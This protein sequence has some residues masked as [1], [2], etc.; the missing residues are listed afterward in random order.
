MDSDK[1]IIIRGFNKLFFEMLDDIILVFPDNVDILS[2]KESFATIKKINPTSII[3]VWHSHIYCEYKTQID[4]GNIDF[5]AEKD[6]KSDLSSV[7]NVNA[8]LDIIN[9]I[10]DPIKSMSSQNK[11]HISK[12]M[13]NL[14]KLSS[15]YSTLN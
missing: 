5:F 13:Q 6:Y 10:R 12:Y 11:E 7:K 9:H 15:V 3:K 2:G 1:T 14:S 4:A 8:I